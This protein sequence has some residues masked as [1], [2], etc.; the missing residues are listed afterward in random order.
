MVLLTLCEGVILWYSLL[1]DGVEIFRHTTALSYQ[2]SNA[3]AA[4]HSYD[5][6]LRACN[7]AGCVTSQTV[8]QDGIVD[9]S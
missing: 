6:H 5:Y 7:S 2:D 1:R 9:C 4:Y 8:R 3:I